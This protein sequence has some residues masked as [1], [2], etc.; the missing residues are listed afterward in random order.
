MP[1]LVHERRAQV[2]THEARTKRSD[3]DDRDRDDHRPHEQ[4]IR[5]NVRRR[6]RRSS[7]HA[8]NNAAIHASDRPHV[9]RIQSLRTALQK[10]RSANQHADRSTSIAGVALDAFDR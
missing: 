6:K 2:V 10:W 7:V 4:T 9:R 5:G 8:A 1:D 3:H